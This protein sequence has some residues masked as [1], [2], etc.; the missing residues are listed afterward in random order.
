MINNELKRRNIP[1]FFVHNGE[2]ISTLEKWEAYRPILKDLFLNSEYGRMPEKIVP[3]IREEEQEINFAGKA[4]WKSVFF[5]FKNNGME[6]TVR[7]ELVLPKS[8]RPAPV[9]VSIGFS[10]DVPNKYLPMEEIIDNGFAVL[11]FFYENVTTDNGDFSNGL[12]PLLSAKRDF[13]KI[14]VWS[15]MA[16]VCMDYLQS[17]DDVDKSAIAVIGHSRLGKTALL[18]SALDERFLLTCVNES[19]C[20]G[21]AL[22]RGK[23]EQN[24]NITT[25]TDV[26]PWWFCEDFFAYRDNED[27]MDFDQHLLLAL[28]APRYAVIGGAIEDVWADNEGQ[29]LSCHLASKAWGF[30]GKGGLSYEGNDLPK[31][32]EKRLDGE[33]GFYLRSGSHFQS[34]EDW[35]VYMKKFREIIEERKNES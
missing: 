30:Y 34:R 29:Y 16:S 32:G 33:L 24:E 8:Q 22:S 7:C 28:V 10:P 27:K 4:V 23:N 3:T 11:H 35:G 20:C 9:F 31:A 13:G 12:Y 14:T 1:N 26:F 25:I 19:G 15:Y 5:T 21:A 18:T 6:H 2:E 17:R